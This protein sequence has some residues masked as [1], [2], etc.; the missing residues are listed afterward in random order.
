MLL[1][2]LKIQNK[3]NVSLLILVAVSVFA[4]IFMFIFD[5][6]RVFIAREVLK[7]ASDAASLASAQDLLFFENQDYSRTAEKVTAINNCKLIECRYDYDE[8]TVTV[9]KKLD[10][11]LIGK[12]M[13][14][15]STIRSSSKAKVIYPWEEQFDYCRSYEFSY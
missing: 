5:F 12:L 7:N 9:E 13:P 1:N 11:I 2:E 10:F 15:C 6:C 8:V 14:G 3:G 4:V